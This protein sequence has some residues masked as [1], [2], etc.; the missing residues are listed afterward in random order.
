MKD[1][2]TTDAHEQKPDSAELDKLELLNQDYVLELVKK[3]RAA[4]NKLATLST[5]IKDQ[6]LTAMAD[7]LEAKVEDLIAANEKDLE[8]FEKVKGSKAMADRL[9]LTPERIKEMADGIRQI[10]KLPDPLGEAP[11]MWTRPNGMQV[12]KIRVPIGVIGIIYESRPNVTADSA[13]LCLKSG[14]V[15][16]LRGGS[17]AIHSNTAI[18][19]ILSEAAEQAACRPARSPSL[20]G[21]IGKWPICS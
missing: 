11:K 6:A 2:S 1:A 5:A 7:G 14:N 17:E 13:A 4:S 18:A 19:A 3:A 21:P 20:S 16:V 9:T 12:G 8:A 10:V 15:C